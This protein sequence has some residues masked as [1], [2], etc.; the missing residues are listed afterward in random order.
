MRHSPHSC[1]WRY[2]GV[3]L[4][5]YPCLD[6]VQGASIPSLPR[7][8]DGRLRC[9]PGMNRSVAAD[10]LLNDKR[11]IGEFPM[12]WQEKSPTVTSEGFS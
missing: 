2:L 4:L 10:R 5:L 9:S 3:S 8:T 6:V 1:L 11:S 12:R 7:L